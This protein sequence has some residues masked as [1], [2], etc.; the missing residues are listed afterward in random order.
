MNNETDNLSTAATSHTE[1]NS[2]ALILLHLIPGILICVVFY[3][4]AWILARNGINAYFALMVV[5]AVI[6]VPVEFGVIAFWG[7]KVNGKMSIAAAISFK[8]R[9][10]AIE[11]WIVPPILFL[12][13]GLLSVVISPLSHSLEVTLTPYV[14]EWVRTESLIHGITTCSAAQ[15]KLT[16]L[17]GIL[18]S[19]IAAPVV[20]E[21]YFRG[22]LLPRMKSLGAGAP[23]LNTLLFAVY[24]I[25]S[26]WN[27]VPI[28]IIFL[29]I[30]YVVW[31]R[32]NM[33]IGIV[34]HCMLNLWS[35]LQVFLIKA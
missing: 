5:I 7:R 20:E 21:M 18:L 2:I 35:V 1:F 8:T 23:I 12:F 22:F 16:F 9:I 3:S 31:R 15:R 10:G 32:K 4:L 17:L 19:G 6:L 11:N 33:T 26:P 29:P 28:F 13:A 27:I 30:T 34:T 25:Y 14:P 24:H